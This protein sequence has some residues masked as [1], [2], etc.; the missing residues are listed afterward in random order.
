MGCI[1]TLIQGHK[2][3]VNNRKSVK[4]VSGPHFLMNKT[5]EVLSS[6]KDGHLG[7]AEV[8]DR[9]SAKLMSGLFNRHQVIAFCLCELVK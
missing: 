4:F 6:R 1:I 2:G 5:L 7:K 8:T 9:K 3:K